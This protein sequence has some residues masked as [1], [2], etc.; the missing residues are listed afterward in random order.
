MLRQWSPLVLYWDENRAGSN[1]LQ[2]SLIDTA[3]PAELLSVQTSEAVW[4][5]L[6]AH[7]RLGGRLPS[8]LVIRPITEKAIGFVR[9]LK[10]SERLRAIPLIVFL[11]D[12]QQRD[13]LYG[14]QANCCIVS[15]FLP[16]ESPTIVP[17]ILRFWL[18]IVV[19]PSA[20]A[21]TVYVR[22]EH[23]MSVGVAT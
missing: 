18:E 17:S 4:E 15:N 16:P 19:L 1:W 13:R 2:Q 20:C 23:R 22:R 14:L 11:D 12:V 10:T 9:E 3:V 6:K 5:Y 7:D 8:L 21:E